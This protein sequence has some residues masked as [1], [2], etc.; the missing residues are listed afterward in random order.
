MTSTSSPIVTF[1]C[2][3]AG[4]DITPTPVYT[5]PLTNSQPDGSWVYY[6]YQYDSS[7]NI[8]SQNIQINVQDTNPAT[9]QGIYL[10]VA[11]CGGSGGEPGSSITSITPPCTGGGGGGGGGGQVFING[12]SDPQEVIDEIIYNG[13]LKVIYE[14]ATGETSVINWVSLNSTAFPIPVFPINIQNLC[15]YNNSNVQQDYTTIQFQGSAPPNSTN[16]V[17]PSNNPSLPV[18][19]FGG[20]GLNGSDAAVGN[21]NDGAPNYTPGSGGKGGD[22]GSYDGGNGGQNPIMYV[23]NNIAYGQV[24][25]GGGGLCGNDNAGD[26]ESTSTVNGK[27]YWGGREATIFNPGWT[28]VYFA[29]GS[30]NSQNNSYTSAGSGGSADESGGAGNSSWIL[31][32]MK[33]A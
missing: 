11:S 19:C 14:T 9:Y 2:T 25:G 7:L 5:N 3:N 1:T 10:T 29:D 22:G 8:T 20:I 4:I 30:S 32:Y 28:P 21:D 23:Y 12:Y 33:L 15:Q 27:S 26:S 6:Y 24:S 13:E 18:C 16:P 31:L 17:D